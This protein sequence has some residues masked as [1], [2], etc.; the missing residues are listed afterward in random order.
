MWLALATIMTARDPRSAVFI[1]LGGSLDR[2][3]GAGHA[4]ASGTRQAPHHVR[5]AL[6]DFRR[7]TRQ[8]I[9][10]L[11]YPIGSDPVVE[12]A[13]S[14]RDVEQDSTGVG[15]VCCTPHIAF[16]PEG[17]HN[18]ARGALIQA[19]LGGERVERGRPEAQE[20]VEGVA[21]GEGDVVA[22]DLVPLTEQVGP[23]EVGQGLVEGL[24]LP[25]EYWIGR[26]H[27]S[28]HRQLYPTMRWHVKREGFEVVA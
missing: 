6:P 12:S 7:K 5:N 10:P 15:R 28:W 19:Q 20:R 26:L 1:E 25:L 13:P 27:C 9:R 21:L 16:A 4:L 14:R 11:G 3:G 23:D 24:D 22:A 8:E 2:L 17:R 18:P